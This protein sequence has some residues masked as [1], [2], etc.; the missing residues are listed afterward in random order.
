MENLRNRVDIKLVNNEKSLTEK[1]LLWNKF[2]YFGTSL[3]GRSKP[4]NE[5]TGYVLLRYKIQL[6]TKNCH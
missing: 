6:N 3:G 4:W 1:S 5:L 2:A